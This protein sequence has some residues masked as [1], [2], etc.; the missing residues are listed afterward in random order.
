MVNIKYVDF[1][2]EKNCKMRGLIKRGR[3]A[4][5]EDGSR[6]VKERDHKM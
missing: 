1:Y 4:L 6:I 3:E 2:V 5:K